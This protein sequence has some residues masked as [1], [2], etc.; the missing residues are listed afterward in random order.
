MSSIFDVVLGEEELKVEPT[1]NIPPNIEEEKTIFDV[2]EP[3]SDDSNS[4]P[5]WQSIPAD[6]L[7]GILEGVSTVGRMFGPLQESRSETQ[8]QEDFTKQLNEL[9]PSDPTFVGGALRRAL[10]LGIPTFAFPGGGTSSTALRSAMGGVAGESVEQLGGGEFLQTAAE[11]IPFF[12]PSFGS[13][14]DP[15][16]S[17]KSLVE[18][19]RSKGAQEGQIAPLL[20][21]DNRTLF[22]IN[23][24]SKEQALGKIAEKG[25]KV[26]ER[27]EESKKLFSNLYKGFR[28]GPKSDIVL[29]DSAST[30]LMGELQDKLYDMPARVRNIIS[31][32]FNQLSNSPKDVKS[33]IKFF[34]DINSNLGPKTKQLSTLKEPIKKSLAL[35]DPQLSREF[36]LTNKLFQKYSSITQKLTPKNND[37]INSLI[38]LSEAGRLMGGIYLGSFP[39]IAEVVGETVARNLAREMLTNPRFQNLTK[40]TLSA[41]DKGKYAIANRLKDDLIKL[42]VKTSPEVSTEIEAF[43]FED[44]NK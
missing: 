2:E 39:M 10:N 8:I 20:Q 7:K 43:D 22:G 13:K 29:S 18:Y 9:L 38:N 27:L 28:E 11:L 6:V 40:Q 12:S 15:T 21:G 34:Q 17:Q 33:I 3:Y 23:L 14:I 35:L 16:K 5:W 41:L 24:P 4:I 30:K 42:I 36:D 25:S 44:L 1:S 19:L 37:I 26:K 31:E 32:D